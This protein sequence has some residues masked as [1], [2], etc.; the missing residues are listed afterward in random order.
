[1][2]ILEKEYL[3]RILFWETTKGCNLRCI[4]CRAT[5]T[6]LSSPDDLTT[7]ECC[8]LIDQI[9]SF[10]TPVI[11]LTGGEPLF[12]RDIFEI[13]S[14]GR[15]KGLRIALATN[16]TLVT[17]YMAKRI[18]AAG[19]KRVS[20]SL[21]GCNAG[22]HDEFRKI[23]GS[24]DLA[25]TGFNN[26]KE[27]GMS[28]QINTTITRHNYKEL[29]EILDLAIKLEA[30]ALH[31]FLL[32]P[33][34]CGVNISEDQMVP[35][36]EYERI[37]NWFYEQSAVQMIDLKATCAPHY[38]RV[39]S[40]RIISDK[41]MGIKP[42]PFVALGTKL[43]AGH[44]DK[45]DINPSRLSAMTKGCLAATGTCFISHKGDIF[46]CG[47]LPVKAGNIKDTPFASIWK[48]SH[49][50]ENLRNPDLLGGKCGICEYKYI[51]EGC[52]ARA[53]SQT[54][55][56]LAE[57]PFCIYTPDGNRLKDKVKSCN[58]VLKG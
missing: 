17:R 25:I 4:H 11:V 45:S 57:E 30:D 46:P 13:A 16:G 41:K 31:T 19:I 52:R 14:Y 48:G 15:D 51:C 58:P 38:F 23:P 42:Q 44:I 5:A 6:E 39:R 22:T 21:D 47:Y 2:D 27:L 28:L 20:I 49:I 8:S 26:L 36:E 9:A 10:A 12:R 18:V 40:Q 1:M 50:F 43:K 55:D 7:E 56:Y 34:G 53:Y 3:P 24:F 32:V 33:V 29:P 54:G 35:V 37:L